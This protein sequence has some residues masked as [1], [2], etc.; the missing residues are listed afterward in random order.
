MKSRATS[1]QSDVIVDW[2]KLDELDPVADD[3]K[4]EQELSL[5]EN[6]AAEPMCD[7]KITGKA[8]KRSRS[9]FKESSE[10]RQKLARTLSS[11]CDGCAGT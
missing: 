2:E 7:M 3:D 10:R 1:A 5:N 9:F 6:K 8:F 11:L 4:D